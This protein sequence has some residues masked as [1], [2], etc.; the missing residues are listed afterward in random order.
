MGGNASDHAGVDME[1]V[2]RLQCRL[3]TSLFTIVDGDLRPCGMGL[4]LAAALLNHD[5]RPNAVVT[6]EGTRLQV[7]GCAYVQFCPN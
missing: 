2:V 5:C 4:Y 3:R 1:E 6:F 7:R